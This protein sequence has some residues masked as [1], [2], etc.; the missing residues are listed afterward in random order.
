MCCVLCVIF[1]LQRYKIIT[2][3]LQMGKLK[4]LKKCSGGSHRGE[5]PLQ[6]RGDLHHLQG[7]GQDCRRACGQASRGGG[8]RHLRAWRECLQQLIFVTS[9]PIGGSIVGRYIERRGAVSGAR[10]DLAPFTA[11]FLFFCLW[12]MVS[13]VELL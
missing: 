8:P 10:N 6:H 4:K 2:Q 3:F 12:R 1:N 13:P 11:P 7:S 5:H 9:E